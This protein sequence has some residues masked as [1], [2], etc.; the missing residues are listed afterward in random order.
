MSEKIKEIRN[1]T[2]VARLPIKD[3]NNPDDRAPDHLSYT[4]AAGYREFGHVRDTKM[5]AAIKAT[6][7]PEIN[8]YV[9]YGPITKV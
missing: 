3:L 6:M 7:C 9:N 5:H 8:R 2:I 4:L 1:Y